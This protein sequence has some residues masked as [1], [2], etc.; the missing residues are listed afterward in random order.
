MQYHYYTVSYY[1]ESTSYLWTKMDSIE[2]MFEVLRDFKITEGKSPDCVM[3]GYMT[4]HNNLDGW[5]P[6]GWPV[7]RF[8][9]LQ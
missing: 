3:V 2:A 1:P 6:R 4:H 5:Q 9:E 8:I 7:G